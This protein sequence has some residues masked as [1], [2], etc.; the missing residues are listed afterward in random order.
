VKVEANVDRQI[1]VFIYININFNTLLEI[2][3]IGL[4]LQSY[5]SFPGTK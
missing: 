1:N 4:F 2:Y 5:F 3:D